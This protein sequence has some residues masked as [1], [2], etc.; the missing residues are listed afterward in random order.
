MRNR[1]CLLGAATA[2][3]LDASMPA[4][5]RAV[6]Q[7]PQISVMPCCYD[8]V[9]ARLV[10]RAGFE[11]TFMTGFGV[12]AARGYADAGLLSFGEMQDSARMI[13]SALKAIPSSPTAT[14]A[15]ATP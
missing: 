12:A 6:L 7:K 3:A 2:A 1:L 13:A 11:L 15:T 5:L 14:R 8:G 9:T 10:E 4:R